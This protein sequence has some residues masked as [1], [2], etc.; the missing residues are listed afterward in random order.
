MEKKN[1]KR[2]VQGTTK[3]KADEKKTNEKKNHT[4]INNHFTSYKGPDGYLHCNHCRR[5]YEPG[6]KCEREYI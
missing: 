2:I 3:K 5:R 4:H 6:H 1:I